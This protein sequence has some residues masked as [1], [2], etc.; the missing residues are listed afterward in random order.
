MKKI[1]IVLL[2]GLA[3]CNTFDYDAFLKKQI[4]EEF[5]QEFAMS[6]KHFKILDINIERS[7]SDYQYYEIRYNRAENYTDSLGFG[8]QLKL[9]KKEPKEKEFSIVEVT[10]EG[11][12]MNSEIIKKKKKIIVSRSNRISYIYKE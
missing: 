10:L 7:I 5:R 3:G 2:I 6:E 9:L 4:S 8:S 11:M 1:L 12:N